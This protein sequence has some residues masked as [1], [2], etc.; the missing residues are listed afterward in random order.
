MTRDDLVQRLVAEANALEG[1][2]GTRPAVD[3]M[4][5]AAAALAVPP[6][7]DCETWR[8]E[9]LGCARC[10]KAAAPPADAAAAQEIMLLLTPLVADAAIV[11]RTY[12]W[13]D[14][15]AVVRAAADKLKAAPPE[16]EVYPNSD[17]G[18]A[19]MF[20]GVS[21]PLLRGIQEAAFRAGRE[22]ALKNTSP[23]DLVA[24]V[25]DWQ[26]AMRAYPKTADVA[27]LVDAEADLLAYPLPD[28]LAAPPAAPPADLVRVPD[29]PSR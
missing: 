3:A 16:V 17:R 9:G 4:R 13:P 27:G 7:H 15:L 18:L 20:P 19:Q 24:R 14:V 10:N 6:V 25:R 1:Y 8:L 5:D 26:E 28:A 11:G 12:D 29:T 21:V 23:A 22:D 2:W